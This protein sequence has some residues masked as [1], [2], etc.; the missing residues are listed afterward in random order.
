MTFEQAIPKTP[1]NLGDYRFAWAVS[2]MLA[3]VSAPL[4]VLFKQSA[5]WLITVPLVL[6]TGIIV[7]YEFKAAFGSQ[8]DLEVLVTF[9]PNFIGQAAYSRLLSLEIHP[10]TKVPKEQLSLFPG[11]T[12]TTPANSLRV[13]KDE[14]GKEIA[15]VSC[16]RFSALLVT[17]LLDNMDKATEKSLRA[18]LARFGELGKGQSDI[19]IFVHDKT[20]REVIK[21][22]FRGNLVT[23][24][25]KGGEKVIKD[26]LKSLEVRVTEEQQKNASDDKAAH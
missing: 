10:K 18:G 25:S 24:V 9:P 7:I 20:V 17:Y 11:F 14:K 19:Q 8:S 1:K 6:G 13:I 5:P 12:E 15:V 3:I 4:I 22:D 26:L 21:S 2:F 16:D 23:L